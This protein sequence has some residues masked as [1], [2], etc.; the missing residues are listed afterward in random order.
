MRLYKEGL[1]RIKVLA[2]VCGALTLFSAVLSP[3]T[4]LVT[5]LRESTQNGKIEMI[6]IGQL[7]HPLL[8][9]MFFAP[10]F[11]FFAFLNASREAFN[12]SSDA[13]TVVG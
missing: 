3:I 2:I 6:G 1:L 4:E 7:T 13:L 10:F 11:I 12:S 9:L 8:I 5:V